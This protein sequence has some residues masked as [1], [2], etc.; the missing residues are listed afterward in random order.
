M[1]VDLLLRVREGVHG[2]LCDRRCQYTTQIANA[3]TRFTTLDGLGE[4]TRVL[5]RILSAR[6]VAK[7]ATALPGQKSCCCAKRHSRSMGWSLRVA[8]VPASEETR[9]AS[10]T[11]IQKN[12]KK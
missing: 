3:A 8:D 10:S 4:Q 6:I 11:S 12:I 5:G 2:S 9:V 7:V 1:V